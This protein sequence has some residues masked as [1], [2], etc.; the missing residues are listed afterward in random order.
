MLGHIPSEVRFRVQSGPALLLREYPLMMR[1]TAP[2]TGIAMCQNAAVSGVTLMSGYGYKRTFWA[3]GSMSAFGGKADIG[4]ASL[5]PN[6]HVLA[7]SAPMDFLPR[8]A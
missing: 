5:N 7:L 6:Q 8:H 1:W 2:A 3:E 4:E